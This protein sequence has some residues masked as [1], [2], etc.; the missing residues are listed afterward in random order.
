MTYLIVFIA[1]VGRA[2]DQPRGPCPLSPL[3]LGPREVAALCMRTSAVRAMCPNEIQTR[4]EC[5][6]SFT[7]LVWLVR[8]ACARGVCGCAG[9]MEMV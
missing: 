7:C 5:T 8:L 1:L 3:Q 6:N 2:A 4:L 9:V